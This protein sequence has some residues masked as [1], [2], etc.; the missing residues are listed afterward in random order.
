MSTVT[1][2]T[3]V[4][5][6]LGHGTVRDSNWRDAFKQVDFERAVQQQEVS[7]RRI[8]ELCT[9]PTGLAFFTGLVVMLV[10]WIMN[11]PMVQMGGKSNLE[12]QQ[13]CGLKIV[14]WGAAAAAVVGLSPV[15]FRA[16]LS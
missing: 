10:L 5:P 4:V 1:F 8:W 14:M 9:C 13:P 3:P 16:M 11:P 12:K 15:F 6:T 2:Q 7:R